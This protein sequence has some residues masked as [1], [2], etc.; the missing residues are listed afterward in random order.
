[1]GL[2]CSNIHLRTDSRA[3][4]ADALDDSLQSIVLDA[5]NGWVSVYVDGLLEQEDGPK[6]LAAS[7]SAKL[8][9]DSISF[10]V[11]D[12]DVVRYWIHVSGEL[13]DEYDSWPGYAEGNRPQPSGGDLDEL[14]RL[15]APGYGVRELRRVMAADRIFADDLVNDLAQMLGIGR[16]RATDDYRF[17]VNA[18]E[19][20]SLGAAV[21][22]TVVHLQTQTS[23]SQGAI[24]LVES[25]ARG[26]VAGL[27]AIVSQGTS[28]DEPA[29]GPVPGS[30]AAA[31]VIEPE[32]TPLIAAIVN[33]KPEAV[34]AL[35]NLGADPNALH[36]LHGSAVHVA[37][38]MGSPEMLGIILSRGGNPNTPG[39]QQQTPLEA[40]DAGRQAFAMIGETRQLMESL[41]LD[42]A[43]LDQLGA[44]TPTASEWDR[45]EELLKSSGAR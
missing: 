20:D 32:M 43:M 28:P 22:G 19:T 31:G 4:V 33:S 13:T 44:H 9:T 12:S 6:Q 5:E 38:G 41:G 35:L 42:S 8:R 16:D 39:V 25:A 7:L 26:D 1:M 23:Y 2:F 3:A 18:D 17:L 40:L 21:A 29:P 30:D 14:A 24:D 11:H 36:E 10:A 27:T 45:C 34:D 37:A 15:S